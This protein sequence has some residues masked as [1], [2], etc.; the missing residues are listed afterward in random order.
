MGLETTCEARFAGQVATGKL[1]LDGTALTF[2]GAFRLD[3]PLAGTTAEARRGQLA[4]SFAA[5]TAA[6]VLGADAE[7]WALRMR[8]PRGRLDKLG[9][10]PAMKVAVLGVDDAAFDAE[11]AGRTAN[12]SRGRAQKD[13]DVVLVG[14]SKKADLERLQG[15]RAKIKKGGAI[16]V[17]W[18]KGR[19]EFRE[20]DV[21][22]HGPAAGLVD[23]KVVSFSETL[24]GLKMVIPV[25]DR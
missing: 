10:K 22:A 4:V 23:V 2:R 15:L 24:S 14:M 8:Y 19:K 12:V 6:F 25:K 17:V 3:I 7:K 13:T 16:W 9:I 5:G 21:R 1:H 11:L 18:P 20:D